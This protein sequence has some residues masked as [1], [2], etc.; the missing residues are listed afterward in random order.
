MSKK[1]YRPHAHN[2]S[3]V[4]PPPSQ[5]TSCNCR[6]LQTQ[7]FL[8]IPYAGFFDGRTD[9]AHEVRVRIGL[10]FDRPCFYRGAKGLKGKRR[11]NEV[12]ER[13][14]HQRREN[15]PSRRLWTCFRTVLSVP[16]EPFSLLFL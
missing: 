5:H 4:N 2:H 1:W 7:R 15:R 8:G 16:G 12:K 9:A 6:P 11:K 3:R 14:A 13:E 10:R